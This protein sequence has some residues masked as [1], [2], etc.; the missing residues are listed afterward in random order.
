MLASGQARLD[1][2]ISRGLGV[3]RDVSSLRIQKVL[4]IRISS[5]GTITKLTNIYGFCL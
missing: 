2:M 5:V 1:R 3:F 4:S